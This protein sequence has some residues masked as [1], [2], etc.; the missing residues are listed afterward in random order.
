MKEKYDEIK[1]L[2]TKPLVATFYMTARCNLHCNYC[3]E[4]GK[5]TVQDLS[6]D[7][8]IQTLE[9]LDR[10]AI[11]MEA[12]FLFGGEP[13]LCADN[14][15]LLLT[16]LGQMKKSQNTRRV[17]FT[18]GMVIP[19]QLLALI[20]KNELDVFLSSDGFGSAAKERYGLAFAEKQSIF[21]HNLKQMH[22]ETSRITISFAVGKHNINTIVHDMDLFFK[23]Y[24]IRSFKVNIIRKN[25]FA[26]SHEKLFIERQ[27]AIIWAAQ[28]GIEL[29]WDS[30]TTYGSEYDNLYISQ[31]KISFQ[32]AGQLGTWSNVSW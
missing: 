12:I 10:Y 25:C 9:D 15:L 20:S 24:Q 26:A 4:L 22:P 27:K 23:D 13:T 32:P 18:N 31:E 2:S 21:L 30:P 16:K 5:T 14:C 3:Y 19:E 7:R 17:L 8:I 29:L 6:P 11:R 28:N 1:A